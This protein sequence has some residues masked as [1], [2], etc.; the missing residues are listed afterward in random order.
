MILTNRVNKRN[1]KEVMEKLTKEYARFGYPNVLDPK[2]NSK[3]QRLRKNM[4]GTEKRKS[5]LWF[6]ELLITTA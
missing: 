3:G 6:H 5:Q 4:R 2:K 1:L